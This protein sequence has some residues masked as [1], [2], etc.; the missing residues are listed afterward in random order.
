MNESND[1]ETLRYIG[2]VIK[3]KRKK[4]GKTQEQLANELGVAKSTISKY[5][6]GAIDIPLSVIPKISQICDFSLL[7]YVPI[8][9]KSL[10][11]AN[12]LLDYYYFPDGLKR[13]S[14]KGASNLYDPEQRKKAFEN[15]E[16]GVLTK[17][18]L[19]NEAEANTILSL[20]DVII[21]NSTGPIKNAADNLVAEILSKGCDEEGT[22]LTRAYIARFKAYNQIKS[23]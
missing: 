17:F 21:S 6:H 11:A 13:M 10:E 15:S 4:A 3:A 16:C 5:E 19:K 9:Q 1:K 7:D 22:L 2:T 14:F 12:F 8:Q 23:T 18:F 20:K